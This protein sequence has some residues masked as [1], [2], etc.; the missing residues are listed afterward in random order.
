MKLG[1]TKLALMTSMVL[2]VVV[3][4]IPGAW[5]Q[6]CPPSPKY[7][8]DFSSNQNC[9]TFNG[10]NYDTPS[11]L[12]PGL[13][14]AVPPAPQGVT[15]VLRLTPNQQAWAGTA[16]YSLQQPV[17]GPFSTTFTFQ[18]SGAGGDQGP[19]D[20]I[21]FVIQNSAT[22]ALG[23]EGCGLGF[24]SSAFCQ[25][26]NGP[27]TGIPNSLAIELNTFFNYGVDPSNSNVAIQNCGAT[28]ANS[29]DPSCRLAVND[30]TL[31][32][33][34]I[35]LADG[36]VHTVTI[37]YSGAGSTLLDVILDNIDLF[38]ATPSNP[39]GGVKFDLTTIGLTNGNAW[40]GFTGATYAADD[41][42][43]IL[44]WNFQPG[45][46]TAQINQNTETDLT[47][48]NQAGTN[49]Y[50][51]NAQLTSPYAEPVVTVQPILLTQNAC[52]AL[53]DKNF[54]PA[55]CFVYQNAQ[56]TGIDSAVM[57]ELTCPNSPGGV[58]NDNQ[59]FFAT[60][61][62]DF[63]FQFSD[64]PF[65]VYPGI[66]GIFNP[67][68][69]WLKGAGPD[70]LHPCTP[71]SKGPLFLSN[72]ITSFSVTGDPG[73]KTKGGSGGTGSCW[74]ATYDTPGEIWPGVSITSPKP[75]TYSKGQSVTAVYACTNPS[76]SKPLSSPVGPYLTAAVCSQL[77]G[78]QTACTQNSNGLSCTGTVDTSSRGLHVFTA[79]GIDSGGNQNAN[80]VVYNVK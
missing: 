38:P 71:P 65:L 59:S 58:C 63:T 46:E 72:Q 28:G 5:A 11:S 61:G 1:H 39:S 56:N 22:T 23:P 4:G 25:V 77:T 18:L 34:P 60:L 48:P 36:N 78:T 52:N 42:Q 13:Y 32:P 20:G 64:N 54:W 12:Y 10:I 3:A 17:S 67:F 37:T 19:G 14:P 53:V 47:F 6:N 41:N 80:V 44:S 29:V 33:N 76:T 51:Y 35:M 40:V 43:D 2:L 31:L 15:T 8:P 50:N 75:T 68:P 45:A 7:L 9:L 73:G 30:L 79:V 21:A 49:V 69:G 74:V 16:W 70:P 62:T 55:Q 24:G 26:P 57:F 66:L 27:Q